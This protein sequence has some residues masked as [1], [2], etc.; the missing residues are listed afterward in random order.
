MSAS[1]SSF[2]P[3][4]ESGKRYG[5]VKGTALQAIGQEEKAFVNANPSVLVMHGLGELRSQPAEFFDE[6]VVSEAFADTSNA[7]SWGKLCEILKPGGKLYVRFPVGLTSAE[8]AS[9]RLLLGGFVKATV[10]PLMTAVAEK[11]SWQA[12]MPLKKKANK[13]S[14]WKLAAEAGEIV[15][16]DALL[17]EN[18]CGG[19]LAPLDGLGP[20]KKK[21]C[22]NC[23]CG[24]ADAEKVSSDITPTPAE[25]KSEAGGCG[26]CAK[27]DA[28]RC[29]GCPY[30]GTPA[31]TPGTKPQVIVKA[32]GTKSLML[33]MTSEI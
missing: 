8:D 17:A 14:V 20:I 11:P 27:G 18:D 13:S 1:S 30:L 26:S 16:E 19:T 4:V 33:D 21:A 9:A 25:E 5:L 7:E 12:A 6:L 31:F 29:G 15:D 28:F 22:K 32:D 23:S 2:F 24:L 3:I 10:S